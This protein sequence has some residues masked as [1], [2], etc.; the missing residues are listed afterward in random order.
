MDGLPLRHIY[1]RFTR[2]RP[3][4]GIVVSGALGDPGV[5]GMPV[6]LLPIENTQP[7]QKRAVKVSM[8]PLPKPTLHDST[9]A[10]RGYPRSRAFLAYDALTLRFKAG[11]S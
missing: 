8:S 1:Q 11:T 3:S 4:A 7:W 2:S 9:A 5:T 10:I 6:F